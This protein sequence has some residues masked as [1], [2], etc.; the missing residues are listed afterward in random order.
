VNTGTVSYS[1]PFLQFVLVDFI[2]GN[3]VALTTISVPKLTTVSGIFLAISC[4]VLVNLV[5]TNLKTCGS[6]GV[7][8]CVAFVTLNAPALTDCLTGFFTARDNPLMTT[9]SVPVLA[10]VWADI[11]FFNTPA[12]VSL[13]FPSLTT[14]GTDIRGSISG[15]SSFS[16]PLLV[17]LGAQLFCDSCPNLTVVTIPNVIFQDGG[18]TITLDSDILNAAS[19]NQVLARGVA[20]A[21]TSNDYELNSPGNAAPT[22]QGILDAAALIIAGN[23]V[24]TN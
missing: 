17:S 4:P 24:N 12:L 6:F 7:A 8:A 10:T 18:N 5:V 13:S 22:G 3:E 9:V 11:Q 15:I 21:T 23:T 14:V 16:A 19:V 20:S 1:F 2:I